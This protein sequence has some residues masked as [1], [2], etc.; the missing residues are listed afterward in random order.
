MKYQ[1]NVET[2]QNTLNYTKVLFTSSY[3]NVVEVS[4]SDYFIPQSGHYVK[5]TPQHAV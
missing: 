3:A 5:R 4:Q 1:I 2:A